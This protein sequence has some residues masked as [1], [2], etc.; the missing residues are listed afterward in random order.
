MRK[1]ESTPC[2]L[3][4]HNKNLLVKYHNGNQ[5][6]IDSIEG[7]RGLTGEQGKPGTTEIIYRYEDPSGYKIFN[8][9]D[10]KK[11]LHMHNEHLKIFNILSDE[12]FIS[13][14]SIILNSE[15][16]ILPSSYKLLNKNQN[17]LLTI[18]FEDIVKKINYCCDKINKLDHLLK[19]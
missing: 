14:K 6:I 15:S 13:A 17:E 10:N 2:E 3:I 11:I 4:N 5:K 19:K 16:V 12:I 18:D 7:P 1:I 9:E 8:I